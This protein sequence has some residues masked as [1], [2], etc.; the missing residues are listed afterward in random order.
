MLSSVAFN[1]SVLIVTRSAATGA[2]EATGA[3]GVVP[4]TVPGCVTVGVVAA[5]G[6]APEAAGF[7]AM[8]L[9]NE[10]WPVCLIHAS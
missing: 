9:R 5:R 10:G 4:A 8:A 2:P 7:G 1:K 3:A 6:A